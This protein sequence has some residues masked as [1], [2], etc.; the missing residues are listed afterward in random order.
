MRATDR[1]S[2]LVRGSFFTQ[3]SR[4]LTVVLTSCSMLLIHSTEFRRELNNVFFEH[5]DNEAVVTLLCYCN[6][7]LLQ[8]PLDF[9]GCWL[10]TALCDT[11]NVFVPL[12]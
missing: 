3:G 1:V 12:T 6:S 9:N 8:N 4:L 2:T 10:T 7:P 5:T 11:N